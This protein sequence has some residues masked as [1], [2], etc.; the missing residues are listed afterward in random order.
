MSLSD[1][2]LRRALL[3]RAG[4]IDPD[5]TDLGGVAAAIAA[6][7]Q[8]RRAPLT[9]WL[10]LAA[11][12]IVVAMGGAGLLARLGSPGE[13]ASASASVT[14]SY[15]STGAGPSPSAVASPSSSLRVTG[16]D[17][18]GFAPS[19]CVRVVAAARARAGD[20]I[21]VVRVLVRRSIDPGVSLGTVPLA[22]VDLFASDGTK[23]SIDLRCF[24]I[25][26]PS[27]RLCDANAEIFVADG[28]DHDVPC[29]PEPGDE[30]HAC[31]T[32]P[33]TP[34]PASVANSTPLRLA[35]LD[36]PLDHLGHYEV[37]AGIAWLPDGALTER[38]ATLADPRP[39]AFWIEGGVEIQVRPDR[40]PG[41]CPV[42]SL[43]HDPYDGPMRVH[44]YLVFD[45]AELNGPSAVLQ[46]RDLVVR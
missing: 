30:N 32:L 34:R 1:D 15:A 2:A 28:V 44:V 5:A 16:C 4:S 29:G 36:I 26:G 39:T 23:T 31:A 33:P 19:R 6:R 37:L 9:A 8:V 14:T 41:G 13:S 3:D 45:V 20:P 18:L 43:Y 11:A 12:L 27:D 17:E 35:S 7:R 40:C 46:V 21:D 22:T 38:S 25:H 10:G 42:S 24:G